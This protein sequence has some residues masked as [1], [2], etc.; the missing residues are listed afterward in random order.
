MLP[1]IDRRRFLS[2][3]ALTATVP[4]FLAKTGSLLADDKSL[5]N[6]ERVLV[7]VQLA[8]GNDG[9]NTLIPFRDDAYYK[10]R[11]KIGIARTKSLKIADDFA[12]HPEV[13]DL[14]KLY[15]AGELAVVPNV[16]YPN[17]NR[18]HFRATEIWETATP[19]KDVLTGW[20]GRYFD[21]ECRGVPSPMLG[22]QLGEKPAM[23][24]AHPKGRAVTLTNPSLFKWDDATGQAM[25]RLNRVATTDNPQ[26]DFLQRTGNDTLSLSR[27]IQ[28]ALKDGKSGA[29][30]APFN[31]SQSLKV[32]AQMIAAEVPTRV[33]YV[34]LGGFDT[35]TTQTG[36]HAGLLQE[37][38]QGIGS[39]VADLKALGHLDRTL[40]MSFSEFGRR[41]SEN[42]QQGT[43]HGTAG[44]M[45]LA[46]GKVKAGVHGSRPD[47]SD[48]DEGDLK[49][50]T[51]FRS[52]YSAVLKDWFAADASKVLGAEFKHLPILA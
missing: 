30:Y 43:D 13:G 40:V 11:P 28:D 14:R 46:G 52:V 5:A 9:L 41:V 1:M 49:F 4:G 51:D 15:D 18:S 38:S 16:G 7:V 33:Y 32:V 42:E 17:P 47:L 3:G 39:F 29:E 21:A 50:K 37:L 26:L 22:L 36:R 24:F 34:S 2:V 27:K 8:G 31:F 20:V 10:A 12:L 25:E 6:K 45:F 44:V 35:H 23:T 19:E 48:L